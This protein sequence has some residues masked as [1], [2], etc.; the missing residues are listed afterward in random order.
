MVLESLSEVAMLQQQTEAGPPTGEGDSL[1]VSSAPTVTTSATQQRRRRRAAGAVIK[2]FNDL[3][4]STGEVLGEG[5]FGQVKTYK[6]INSGKEFAVKVV[7]KR[8]RHDRQKVLKEIE[9]F[10]Y[11]QGHD[12]ILQL[13]EFYEEESRF[14]VIFE[15]MEGGTLLDT[16]L[17]RGHLSERDASLI[18][19]DIARGL[20]FLHKMGIA[21]R[22]LKPENI[23]CV[24]PDQLTPVKICDFDLGSGIQ[25]DYEN[26]NQ[27]VTTPE[28]LSP[29]GSADFMAPEVVDVWL[30][31]GWSYDKRC[32]VWSLG[33]ILY[34]L[35][36]GYRPFYAT[37]GKDCGF[38][39]GLP[40]EE[41]QELLFQ[42]IR[43]GKFAFPESEW[44]KISP[45]G[46]DLVS[47][48]LV[49][50]PQQRYTANQ[51]L[52]HPW[53]NMQD[54]LPSSRSELA[55]PHILSR[56]NSVRQLGLFAENANAVNRLIQRHMSI[57]E[58]CSRSFARRGD[59]NDEEYLG[60]EEDDDR[61]LKTVENSNDDHETTLVGDAIFQFNLSDDDDFDRGIGVWSEDETD[62]G[63]STPTTKSHNGGTE[64]KGVA[65]PG[66]SKLAK[67]R[68][69]MR[70]HR[71]SVDSIDSGNLSGCSPPLRGLSPLS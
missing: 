36:C 5:S 69:A 62:G 13:I 10:H 38:Q 37:C 71:P 61:A 19:R 54:K 3:Y 52:E 16:I 20:S 51:V 8:G 28:L 55:T 44:G 11:C 21:H 39:E 46:R 40:C 7:E 50:D 58:A 33:I 56:T 60:N 66:G 34:I 17:K 48:L 35:L 67:R 49:R 30:D 14:Y 42:C 47:H 32:D 12:N 59:F 31:R 63:P 18:V 43:N 1:A 6:N 22:D 41:C 53:I 9:I 57:N 64:W 27:F 24:K 65:L 2:K 23:L 45:E 25:L 15:K 26:T 4:V 68:Q 70:F 29:V